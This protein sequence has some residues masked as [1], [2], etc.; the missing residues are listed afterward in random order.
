MASIIKADNIQKVS[1]GSNIIKKCGSTITLGSCG[2]TIALACGATQTGFGRTGTVDW[3]TTAK[4]APF[5]GVSGNGYF[6]NTTCGAVTVTLPATPS[7]G[8]IISIADYASTFQT[9]NLTL[10]NNGSLINGVCNNATLNVQGQSI[11]LVYVD[12]T[13][14]W[15]NTMDSTSNVTASPSY[16]VATGGTILTCGDYKT[17]VFTADGCF[18]VTNIGAPAGSTT[19][20]YVVI[21]GG[22]GG[23]YGDAGGGGAGGFRLSNSYSIS[24]PT[25]SPLANP[26][27]LTASL[28]NYSI[29]VGAGGSG[30][31]NPNG[32]ASAGGISTFGP[33]TSTGGGRG[34][35]Y[36][37]NNPVSLVG[38]PGGSGSGST[39]TSPVGLGNTPP[40]SPP[41]GNDGA[42]GAPGAAGGG[43]GAG[44]LGG[45]S[46]GTQVGGAGGIGSYISDTFFGPT[47]PSY[48]TPGPVGSTRYFAGGAGGYGDV[49]FGPAPSAGGGGQ[50]SSGPTPG[51]A[52][53]TN[54]GG[55]GGTGTPG[56]SGYAGGSGIVMIRYKYQN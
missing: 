43:G 45:G 53:T 24:A 35:G 2:A 42:A 12:G 5:T 37:P 19:L 13:K 16:I 23:G 34:S 51:T 15:K 9:N 31:T 32:L 17:H 20:D 8:D 47:A 1:D 50:G 26:T 6:V 28:Q 27:G 41:Q 38:G 56:L 49:T 36:S 46:P 39:G 14:G 18:S 55:G 40:V 10:C 7:A 30:G 48:G 21:A 3:C 11:T 44:G 54:T 52:G 4:T 25:M 29:T 22:G 33:I